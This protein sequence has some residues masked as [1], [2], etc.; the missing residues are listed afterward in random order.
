MRRKAKLV[1]G[2][3]ICP[4]L[5]G[6]ARVP[7]RLP[8]RSKPCPLCSERGWLEQ[9]K[10]EAVRDNRALRSGTAPEGKSII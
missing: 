2:Y 9:R 10:A 5:R 7:S 6:E 1:I 8:F 3:G 4:D